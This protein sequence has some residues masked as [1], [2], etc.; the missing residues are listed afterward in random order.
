M[1]RCFPVFP[2]V[3]TPYGQALTG[4]KVLKFDGA[5]APRVLKFDGAIAPRVLKFDSGSAAEGCC[6]RLTFIEGALL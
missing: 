4:L 6:G 5:I 3:D 1:G 2:K